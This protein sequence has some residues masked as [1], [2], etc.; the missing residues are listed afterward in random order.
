MTFNT[1]YNILLDFYA[2][3]IIENGA[4]EWNF[5]KVDFSRIEGCIFIQSGGKTFFSRNFCV[6][7]NFPE[8]FVLIQL[9]SNQQVVW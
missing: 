4:S 2:W 3:F 9:D 8:E 5:S 1:F 6:F 7:V